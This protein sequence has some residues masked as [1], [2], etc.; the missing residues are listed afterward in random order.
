MPDGE[1]ENGRELTKFYSDACENFL[2][3][4]LSS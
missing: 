2:K 3:K 1:G 4:P